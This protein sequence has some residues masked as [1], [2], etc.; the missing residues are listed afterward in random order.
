MVIT[1]FK[2]FSCKKVGRVK[3]CLFKKK[4]SSSNVEEYK[5]DGK[6]FALK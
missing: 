5:T 3:G 4:K 1:V 2:V 6:Y